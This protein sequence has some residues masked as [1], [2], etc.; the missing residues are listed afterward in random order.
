[1][2]AVDEA[3]SQGVAPSWGWPGDPCHRAILAV[4]VGCRSHPFL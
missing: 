2:R 4:C 3:I 1:M